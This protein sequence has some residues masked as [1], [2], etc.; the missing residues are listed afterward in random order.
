[1]KCDAVDVCVRRTPRHMGT[2]FKGALDM[3]MFSLPWGRREACLVL[4]EGFLVENLFL[5]I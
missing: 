4:G 1:M 3:G 5:K 2:N